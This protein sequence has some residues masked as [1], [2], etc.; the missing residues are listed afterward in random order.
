VHKQTKTKNIEQKTMEAE[1]DIIRA[2][3]GR[4][5]SNLIAVTEPAI[6]DIS[7]GTIV[8]IPY[9][10]GYKDPIKATLMVDKNGVPIRANEKFGIVVKY[11]YG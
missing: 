1:F 6:P 9:A 7:I 2:T 11:I 4:G 5:D 8:I 10:N 3:N